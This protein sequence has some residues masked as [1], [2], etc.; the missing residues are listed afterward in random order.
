MPLQRV[1]DRDPLANE[2]F[3]VIDEQPQVELG[4]IQVRRRQGVQALAQRRAGDRERVDAVGLPAPARLAPRRRHQRGMHAQDTLP[5]LD[6][7]P[8]QRARDMPAILNRP[9]TVVAQAARPCEQRRGA[10]G[11]RRNRLLA[12]HFARCRNHGGDR[13]RAL[14]GVRTE[15]DH[16][17]VHLH[18]E[19]SWTP[20][21]HGLLGAVPRSYQ[22]TPRHPRPATSDTA[23]GSQTRRPTA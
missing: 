12:E 1:V 3:A 7:K 22:V 5:A 9:H 2:S 19:P 14:V 13:V 21:G 8:L 15:H 20:G 11:A 6:Q 16:D 17:L 4:P 23:K 10:L 18:L